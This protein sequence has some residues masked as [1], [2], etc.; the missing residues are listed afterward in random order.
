[1]KLLRAFVLAVSLLFPLAS[2]SADPVPWAEG[3]IKQIVG[4]KAIIA[5]G[6]IESIGMAPMTMAF[7]VKDAAGLAK[8]KAGDKVRFQAVMAG[9]DIVVTRIEAAK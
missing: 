7:I 1:M 5:H 9:V 6:P 3:T 2:L 4:E 8:L